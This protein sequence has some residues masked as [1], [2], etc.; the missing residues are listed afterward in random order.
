MLAPVEDD[1]GSIVSTHN[2]REGVTNHEWY[3]NQRTGT[4]SIQY[5]PAVYAVQ[6]QRGC[7]EVFYTHCLRTPAEFHYDATS[8]NCVTTDR[9]EDQ[10]CARGMNRFT[11]EASC[12]RSCVRTR[13]PEQRCFATPVFSVCESRDVKVPQ[14]NFD[15]RV[16]RRWHFPSGRCPSTTAAGERMLHSPP[17]FPTYSQCFEACGLRRR[18][19]VNT[20]NKA[21]RVGTAC[22]AVLYPKTCTEEQLRYPY[23]AAAG[24]REAG[25]VR[26]W[27]LPV[28]SAF[29]LPGHR[30]LLGTNRFRTRSSCQWACA[31]TEV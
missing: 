25:N 19:R 30:C 13:H 16:C 15:G 1:N 22:H 7:A 4:P 10:L 20:V 3:T 8:Q 21:S 23:F 27:C 26:L 11:S 2:N 9:R 14:W 29:P 28:A 6:T 18:S 17:L 5:H 31:D 24:R 12:T